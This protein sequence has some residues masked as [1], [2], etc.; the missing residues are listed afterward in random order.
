MTRS[1]EIPEVAVEAAAR[2]TWGWRHAALLTAPPGKIADDPDWGDLTETQRNAWRALTRTAL[3]AAALPYLA[4]AESAD[5][6]RVVEL[7]KAELPSAYQFMAWSLVETLTDAGVI[8]V[9][10][11]V[12]AA[13]HTRHP[14]WGWGP[15]VF[16][17]GHHEGEDWNS[18]ADRLGRTW[19]DQPPE[20]KL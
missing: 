9:G 3:E 20:E 7:L 17:A 5:R 6:E 15:C 4:P 1:V 13:V 2:R 16:T 8:K 19:N 12:C 11:P 18:H 10:P 14:E